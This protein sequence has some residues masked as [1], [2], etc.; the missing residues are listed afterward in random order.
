LH[1]SRIEKHKQKKHSN[2]IKRKNKN[3]SPHTTAG[4][5]QSRSIMHVDPEAT[6]GNSVHLITLNSA[7]ESRKKF[8]LSS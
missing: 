6:M 1:P 4:L 5:N 7:I 8:S 2:N 3:S